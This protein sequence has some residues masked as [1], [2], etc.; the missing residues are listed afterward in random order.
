MLIQHPQVVKRAGE[1]H[2]FDLQYRK[3]VD[4]YQN[5]FP[6]KPEPA[7][8]VGEKSPYYLFH[9]HVPQRVHVHYPD[10]K[11]III[12][13]NPIDRAYSHY[14]HNVRAENESL[15]FAEA[16][17]AEP[18]RLAGQK[19]KL[20]QPGYKSPSYL[21]YSYLARGVYVEQ[22][23]RWLKY[24]PREQIHIVSSRDLKE[25]PIE[26]MNGLFAFLGLPDHPVG[27]PDLDNRFD[28][29]RMDPHLRE[30][31]SAYFRPYN[32]ELENLLGRK[33]HWD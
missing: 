10:V 1:I 3:G 19:K 33:F 2:F 15:S 21:K 29:P 27:Y 8:Q 5:Q 7:F 13:R 26:T 28:Y 6:E 30:E 20:Q 11:L 23:R 14:W 9:P 24:F 25:K 16:L 31:L 18:S 22:I 17:K 32:Q 4:W 12:L